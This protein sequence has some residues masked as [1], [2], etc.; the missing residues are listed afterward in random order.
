[1]RHQE[2]IPSEAVTLAVSL[3]GVMARVIASS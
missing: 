3:D 1:L 2:E